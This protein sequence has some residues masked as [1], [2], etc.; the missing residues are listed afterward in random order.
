M[1]WCLIFMWRLLAWRSNLER[2]HYGSCT[3]CGKLPVKHWNMLFTIA[4]GNANLRRVCCC[5]VSSTKRW[6][7]CLTG[8]PRWSQRWQK[9]PLCMETWTPSIPSWTLTR[10]F[11][12]PLSLSLFLFVF[13]C[14]FK[15]TKLTTFCKQTDFVQAVQKLAFATCVRTIVWT[16]KNTKQH[17]W[18]G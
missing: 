18:T 7:L 1:T 6:T 11:S 8:W 14:T 3:W 9:T 16:R 10:S 4:A 12:F 17:D 2:G 5:R 15:Q 13:W